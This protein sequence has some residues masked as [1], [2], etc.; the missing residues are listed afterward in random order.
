MGHV[1]SDMKFDRVAM[2]I[3]D[4]TTV[5]DRGNRYILVVAD[6]FTKYIEAYALPNKTAHAVADVFTALVITVW[7]PHSNT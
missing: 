2:D 5:S 1:G 4:I 7:F 3:L 6:Y